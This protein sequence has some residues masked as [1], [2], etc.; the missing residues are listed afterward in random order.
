MDSQFFRKYAD[1]IT[2]AEKPEIQLDEGVVDFLKQAASKVKEKFSGLYSQAAKAIPGFAQAY[3]KAKTMEQELTNILQSSKSATEAVQKVK[4]LAGGGVT[5]EGVGDLKIAGGA[6]TTLIG[7]AEGILNVLYGAVGQAGQLASIPTPA[8]D[9]H[10]AQGV[11][12]TLGSSGAMMLQ[13]GLPV[14]FIL[15][16]LFLVYAGHTEK[17]DAERVQRNAQNPNYDPSQD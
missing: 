9:G 11:F 16:G 2:E 10:L 4:S 15:A 8:T 5:A 17:S 1:L 7:A 3:A 12:A 14:M 6:V 13:V